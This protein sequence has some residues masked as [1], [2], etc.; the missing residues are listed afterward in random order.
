[1]VMATV[2]YFGDNYKPSSILT[3]SHSTY[4]QVRVK[5]ERPASNTEPQLH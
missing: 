1:M 4:V 5:E 3:L 2:W